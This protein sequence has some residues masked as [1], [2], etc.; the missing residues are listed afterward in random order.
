MF[1]KLKSLSALTL[2]FAFFFAI[3]FTSCE[4]KEAEDAEDQMEEMMEDAEESMEELMEEGE[5]VL[6]EAE[7]GMEDEAAL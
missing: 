5:E 6:E 1:T 2:A 4:E 3:G 7:E